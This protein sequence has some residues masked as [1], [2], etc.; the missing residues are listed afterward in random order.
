MP[1]RTRHFN[2]NM[3]NMSW[4]VN[5]YNLSFAVF[6]ITPSRIADQFGRKRLFLIG[7][8]FF[9]VTSILCGVS[10]SVEAMIFFRVLQGLSAGIVVPVT[11][12][13]ATDLFPKEKHVMI[14]GIWA[15]IPSLAAASGPTLGGILTDSIGWEAIFFVNVPIG[16]LV[17]CLTIPL[18]K[19]SFDPSADR[20][21]DWLG[22]LTLLVAM[23]CLTYGLINAND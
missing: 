18:I 1:E 20:K 7:T 12:P 22:I 6:L 3:D 21:I 16:I 10:T 17:I 19:E 23:F 2:N 14:L 8:L 13:L 9:I 5:G 15:A 11:I 4:I